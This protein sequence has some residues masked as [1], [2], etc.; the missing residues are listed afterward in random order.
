MQ[1][2]RTSFLTLLAGI[3]VG[4]AIGS[5][6][7]NPVTG[8]KELSLVSESQEIEMGRSYSGQIASEMGVYP[9]SGLRAYVATIGRRMALASER[10]KLP[11]TFYVMDDPQVNAFALPGGF[12]FVTRGILA[13]MNSEAELATVVGHEIGHVTARHSVQ[14]MTRTQ[15][16]QIGLVAG[17]IAS[18]TF[19]QYAGVATQG[20]GILFLKYGRDDETQ[21]DG[22]GFRYALSDGYDV[23][24]MVD[25]FQIL[26]RV[27]ARAGQRI[28]EWQSSHPDPGNRI[29]ATQQRLSKVT[30]PLDGK[31][32]NRAEFL[33]AIDG[34]VFG[35][36]PRQGYFQGAAFLHP[37]LA[38]EIDF[39]AGWRTANQPAA[40]VGVS[41]NRDAQVMLSIGA[42]SDPETALR[43]FLSKEGIQGGQVHR[44]TIHGNQAATA[45]FSAQGEGGV[46]N[47]RATYVAYA[48]NTYQL[49]GVTTA[50]LNSW[51]GAF[52]VFSDSFR[53]LT[54]QTALNVKPNRIAITRVTRQMTLAEFNRQYPSV[55]PMDEL[56]LIN[57]VRDSTAL[58][59]AGESVKR[60][61]TK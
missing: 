42:A 45:P 41:P 18:E 25:M 34:I 53:R 47:G 19:A 4:S 58:I 43:N 16:A 51:D 26:K 44:T 52:Q 36:N 12:I 29:E 33:R 61:V 2:K 5:C 38:F 40:V 7:V 15:L 28:P 10:P 56:A 31:K 55:I 59:P 37:D 39:P 8:K 24:Q 11:W 1:M 46:L 32:V 57:G 21:A 22:L 14:Q 9:D 3:A 49:L 30:V 6:A 23:R 48:G 13:H 50:A 20:L 54:D 60:V 17:S 35:D 27:G